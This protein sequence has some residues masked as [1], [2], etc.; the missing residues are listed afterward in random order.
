MMLASLL[1]QF[2]SLNFSVVLFHCSTLNDISV[3][4]KVKQL[5]DW[6]FKYFQA[7]SVYLPNEKNEKEATLVGNFDKTINSDDF[8]LIEKLVNDLTLDS[9]EIVQLFQICD[10]YLADE[11][12]LIKLF[13]KFLF[14]SS[15]KK[16]SL[17][18]H[19]TNM[20]I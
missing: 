5:E 19:Y 4:I 16:I 3:E 18:C 11:R 8:Q 14:V 13:E 6:G 12:I 10:L 15:H 17:P 9:I 20:S 1:F 7:L 2:I